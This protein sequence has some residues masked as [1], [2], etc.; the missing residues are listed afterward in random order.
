[1]INQYQ[2]YDSKLLA[3]IMMHTY[4]CFQQ[5]PWRQQ[6]WQLTKGTAG[7]QQKGLTINSDEKTTLTQQNKNIAIRKNQLHQFTNLT[8][9]QQREAA[10]G[11]QQ[12][13]QQREAATGTDRLKQR[14]D[15]NNV[16]CRL[17]QLIAKS[18][19]EKSANF[20]C[21]DKIIFWLCHNC[22]NCNICHNLIFWIF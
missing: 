14:E 8:K 17:F 5:S 10:A 4:A 9:R 18:W 16:W 21:C 20:G 7:G 13:G 3:K 11:K 6:H 2:Y 22:H 12:Q 15:I 1:M 19:C